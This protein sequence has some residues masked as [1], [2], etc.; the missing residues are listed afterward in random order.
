M[1]NASRRFLDPEAI[2]RVQNLEFRTRRVVEGLISG[3]HRSPLRG[4]SVEFA[5]HREYVPGD[6]LRH[7]D[8]KVWA[9]G[10]RFYIKQY[11]EETNLRATVLLDCSTSMQ[12]GSGESQKFDFSCRLA[13]ALSYLLL[14]QG[15]AVGLAT[16]DQTLRSEVPHRNAQGHLRAL[17]TEMHVQTLADRS[18]LVVPFRQWSDKDARR[19]LVLVL[20]DLLAPAPQVVKALKALARHGHDLVVFHV[21]HD[22]EID[23]PFDGN[24]RFEAME[25]A[26]FV[27]C[28]PRALRQDYLEAF[29]RYL[30]QLRQFASQTGTDYRL[31]RTSSP[32]ESVLSSF[33]GERTRGR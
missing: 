13:A 24:T 10:D 30:A 1:T 2:A 25:S 29:E 4:Q 23:F 19:G 21:L 20:S 22:D 11:E 16:F 14:R 15:D 27:Q 17:L 31:L 32:V 12:Y 18:D 28:D 33:L 8:W 26:D 6:D 3:H 5:Q 7:L 9:K